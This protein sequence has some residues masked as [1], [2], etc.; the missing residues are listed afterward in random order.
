MLYIWTV[1]V[2]KDVVQED[3]DHMAAPRVLAF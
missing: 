1:T 3:V 2:E